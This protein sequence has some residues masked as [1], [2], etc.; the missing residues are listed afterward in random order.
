MNTGRY[1]H[2]V[3]EVLGGDVKI[4]SVAKNQGRIHSPEEILEEI[5]SVN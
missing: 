4:V 5:R 1:V 3:K 2:V